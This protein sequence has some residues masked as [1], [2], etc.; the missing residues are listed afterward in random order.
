MKPKQ[1]QK[2]VGRCKSWCWNRAYPLSQ[3]L[4]DV[5]D[6]GTT[7]HDDQEEATSVLSGNMNISSLFNSLAVFTVEIKC[8][9]NSICFLQ[10]SLFHIFLVFVKCKLYHS[11]L[12]STYS[13]L[14]AG[15]MHVKPYKQPS[16][17]I[18]IFL[19]T[20]GYITL[21]MTLSPFCIEHWSVCCW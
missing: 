7:R 4:Y 5:W 17:I 19:W 20:F 8:L 18:P 13:S 12:V 21:C 15:C 2:L 11:F 16:R 10:W 14:F 3:L 6:W 1:V 9:I